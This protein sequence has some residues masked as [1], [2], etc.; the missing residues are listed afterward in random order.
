MRSPARSLKVLA[1]AALF[2]LAGATPL[3]AQGTV[4][5]RAMVRNRLED[6]RDRREDRRDRREDVLDRREGLR[7]RL[8]D[9]RD[10]RLALR[11]VVISRSAT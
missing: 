10:A 2:T 9:R 6:V 1:T 8:E 7:D 4:R 5:R 11:R 3:F